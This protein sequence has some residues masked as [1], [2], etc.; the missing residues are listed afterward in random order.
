MNSGFTQNDDK[1]DYIVTCNGISDLI[2]TGGGNADHKT[3]NGASA[4]Q[5]LNFTTDD[6]AVYQTDSIGPNFNISPIVL[7][8]AAQVGYTPAVSGNWPEGA[9]VQAADAL[10][11]LAAR[12]VPT[13]WTDATC[14]NFWIP[15]TG[16]AGQATPGFAKNGDGL[17]SL[18]GWLQGGVSGT[19]AF[20]LPVEYRPAHTM[21]FPTT[22]DSAHLG[23]IQ[24]DS[25]G[26]V[27][28]YDHAGESSAST[29]TTLDSIHFYA[30]S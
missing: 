22:T 1:T 20:V 8:K 9:P 28:V 23:I 18:R 6:T 14:I 24:I 4:A 19:T 12:T 11:K 10:D 21:Q 27:K 16:A 25:G 13:A 5:T 15:Y 2:V 29:L 26:N 17:V 7:S 30:G 3:M